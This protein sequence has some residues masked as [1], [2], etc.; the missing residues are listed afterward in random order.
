MLPLHRRNFFGALALAG[1]ASAEPADDPA[2]ADVTRRLARYI[3]SSQP[4]DLPQ[5]VRKEAR[6]TLLNWVGCAIGGSRH[7]TVD[8]AIAALAPFAGPAQSSIL[9]RKE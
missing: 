5:A 8:I 3:V 2:A 7:E 6:R 4:A 1:C 9:G